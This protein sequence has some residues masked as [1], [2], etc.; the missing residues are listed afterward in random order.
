MSI[1]FSTDLA[2]QIGDW[3]ARRNL[4]TSEAIWRLVE[5]ALDRFDQANRAPLV[6]SPPPK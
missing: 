4:P 1:R 5:Q 6:Q 3:A 2:E